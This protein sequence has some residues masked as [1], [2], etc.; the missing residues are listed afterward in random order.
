VTTS[1][2]GE[3]G[4]PVPAAKVGEYFATLERQG[5][6]HELRQLLQR[7]ANSRSGAGAVSARADGAELERMRA[8]M[9][10]AMRAGAMGMTTALIYPPSSYCED[11]ELIEVAKVAAKY[12]GVYAVTFAGKALMSCSPSRKPL[13]SAKA[14]D[15]SGSLPLKVAHQPGWGVLMDSIR[16]VVEA[17]RARNVDVAADL[18]VYTAGGRASRRRF[19]AGHSRVATTRFVR[20]STILQ[21]ARASRVK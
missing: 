12:G 10:T 2:G 15:S 13:R 19:R 3:G 21:H 14:Q 8:I 17:A 9:D 18:Y 7:N 5:H 4:T 20:A 6:Q 11:D 1:I 16:M